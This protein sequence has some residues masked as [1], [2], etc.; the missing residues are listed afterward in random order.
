MKTVR[1]A[2]NQYTLTTSKDNPKPKYRAV[3][4]KVKHQWSDF[5]QE[6]EMM[7][8]C[9]VELALRGYISLESYK[10]KIDQEIRAKKDM[11]MYDV[12]L[13]MQIDCLSRADQKRNSRQ[14]YEDRKKVCQVITAD[15]VIG[16]LDADQFTNEREIRIGVVMKK[17]VGLKQYFTDHAKTLFTYEETWWSKA[18]QKT[19]GLSSTDKTGSR[20]MKKS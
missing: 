20:I 4:E 7:V 19:K 15:K 1:N 6:L 13:D 11:T 18:N 14:D 2:T 9:Q 8:Y 16:F 5:L 12:N 3:S 10:V 17:F